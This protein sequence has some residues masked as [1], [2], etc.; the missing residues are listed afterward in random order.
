[1]ARPKTHRTRNGNVKTYRT[2]SGFI[3]LDKH[4]NIIRTTPR[5]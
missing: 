5:V 4:G 2:R 1:M 3:T